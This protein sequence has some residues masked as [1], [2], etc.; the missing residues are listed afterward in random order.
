[1]VFRTESEVT[2][3][4]GEHRGPPGLQRNTITVPGI[5]VG[6]AWRATLGGALIWTTETAKGHNFHLL[7]TKLGL[8]SR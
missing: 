8:I 4:R 2:K 3:A 1:M 6:G 5:A 7:E